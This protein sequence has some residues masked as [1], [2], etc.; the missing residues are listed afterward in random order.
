MN[1]VQQL[2]ISYVIKQYLF[3]IIFYNCHFM[4]E[5]K[6]IIHIHAPSQIVWDTLMNFQ[7][8]PEW[9]PFIREIEG[10][11][12]T[13]QQ[14]S[15]TVLPPES[16]KPMKFSPNVLRHD[17]QKEFRWKGKLLINGLF[18]GEHYFKLS[19][20]PNGSTSLEHGERFSG[21]MVPFLGGMLEKTELGFQQMNIALKELCEEKFKAPVI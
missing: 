11:V 5:I 4:K 6:T 16:S 17:L 15:V 1:E 21:L 7:E 13:G 3:D 9:N 2:S 19:Q 20:L 12:N 8:Y 14:L 18:D 10:S